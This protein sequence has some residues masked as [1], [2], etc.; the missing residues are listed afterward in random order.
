MKKA[1]LCLVCLFVIGCEE[2]DVGRPAD[3]QVEWWAKHFPGS[4]RAKE[5]DAKYGTDYHGGNMDM[6]SK[7]VEDAK[8]GRGEYAGKTGDP[9]IDDPDLNHW[10]PSTDTK[11]SFWDKHDAQFGKGDWAGKTGD[12]FIDDPFFNP[13]APGGSFNK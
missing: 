5:F 1:I 10:A 7:D 2:V 13:W 4:I 6:S 9:S 3:K 8:W 11:P 12:P